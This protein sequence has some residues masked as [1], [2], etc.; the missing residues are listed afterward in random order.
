MS[1]R[2]LFPICV[3]MFLIVSV[4]LTG[5]AK[6]EEPK[7]A[8]TPTVQAPP[9]APTVASMT[10]AK[11]VDVNWAAVNPASEFKPSDRINVTIRTE[12]AVPGNQL[13]VK[14]MYLDTQQLVKAD[15]V[16]LRESGVNNSA[17]FIERAKGFPAGE[18]RLDAYLNGSLV[19]SGVFK[20][21]Q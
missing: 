2:S 17:F 5:C 19:K 10:F 7:P 4:G 16:V 14:W 1:N 20:V 12:N 13:L 3:T 18:Y 6:K 9:P 11:G 21:A 15:S 8:P